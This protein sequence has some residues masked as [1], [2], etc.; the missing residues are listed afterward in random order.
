MNPT[1]SQD[2]C[3]TEGRDQDQGMEKEK[4]DKAQQGREGIPVYRKNP[5][6]RKNT[7]RVVLS[8]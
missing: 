2:L 5:A 6:A 1:V 4:S 3:R 7:A 8:T